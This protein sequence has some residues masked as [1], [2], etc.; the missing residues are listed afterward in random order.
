M[1]SNPVLLVA[2]FTL[3]SCG[4]P[5]PEDVPRHELRATSG[6]YE[7]GELMI[8][9]TV[10]TTDAFNVEAIACLRRFCTKKVRPEE[11]NDYWYTPDLE[12]FGGIH[13][14]LLYAE[15]DSVGEPSYPP[16]L[17]AIRETGDPDQR[18]MTVRWAAMD[19]TGVATRVRYVFDF[20]AKRTADGVRL[21]SPLDHLT[22][23]WGRKTVGMVEYIISPTHS[24][25]EAQ[26]QQQLADIHRLLLF[27]DLPPFPIHFYSCTDPTELFRIRGYQHHPLMH[28]YPT[29][30]R[31]EGKDI[32]FSGNNKDVYTHEIVHL[33]TGRKF[34]EHSWVLDEG[35]ATVLAGSSEH[36]FTWHRSNLKHYLET[37]TE[38]DLV[39][40]F[41]TYAP[42]YINE[43]TNVAYAVGG[44]LC[45]RILRRRGKDALFKAF[46]SGTDPWPVLAEYDITRETLRSELMKELALDPLI[47]L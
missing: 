25:S 7:F 38:V 35:L 12:R 19:S 41:S 36:P 32:V 44:V 3:I 9:P 40:L 15:F 26:A 47:I 28:L 16:T 11:S 4:A 21:G 14:E 31:A 42:T 23:Q 45:E 17:L 37:G 27:F 2:A 34:A 46:S 10:D 33:F 24:F 39:A 1:M 29:G 18:A 43:H 13:Q 22:E 5:V 8:W 20:L 30:G 6:H